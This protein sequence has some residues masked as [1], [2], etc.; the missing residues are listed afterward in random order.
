MLIFIWAWWRHFIA[1][2]DKVMHFSIQSIDCN[3]NRN[4]CYNK[5]KLWKFFKRAPFTFLRPKPVVFLHFSFDPDHRSFSA[6]CTLITRLSLSGHCRSVYPRKNHWDPFWKLWCTSR[7]NTPFMILGLGQFPYQFWYKMAHI[8]LAG[9]SACSMPC[10]H[11]I[12]TG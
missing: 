9:C 2:Y 1:N 3:T 12:S 6:V 5:Q 10:M 4:I 11:V 7:Y 8:G